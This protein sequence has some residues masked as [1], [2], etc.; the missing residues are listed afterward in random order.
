MTQEWSIPQ[1]PE[2][3]EAVR[4]WDGNVYRR[5]ENEGM[6]DYWYNE[7]VPAVRGTYEWS[8]LLFQRGPVRVA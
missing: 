2:D 6:R 8:D 3:L 5:S 1:P 7:D 4:D